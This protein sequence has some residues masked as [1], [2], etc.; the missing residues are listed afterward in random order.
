MGV[1]S[2]NDELAYRDEVQNLTVWCS[3]NNL[4]LNNKKTKEIV[5]DFR[6]E[7]RTNQASVH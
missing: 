4:I 3:T 6:N 2:N 5:V 7:R 1:I